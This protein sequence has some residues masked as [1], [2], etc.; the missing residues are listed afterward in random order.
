MTELVRVT[1]RPV[2]HE[3]T[4]VHFRFASL[5]DSMFVPV[6]VVVI[7]VGRPSQCRCTEDTHI[8]YPVCNFACH[9]RMEKT[10]GSPYKCRP[11]SVSQN[12]EALL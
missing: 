6:L 9:A 11:W 8:I 5:V 12:L 2:F 1:S 4:D 10:M 3:Y 7:Q